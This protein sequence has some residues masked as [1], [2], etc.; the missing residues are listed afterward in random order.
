MEEH[1]NLL[2]CPFC[3]GRA[4][5]AGFVHSDGVIFCTECYATISDSD[6]QTATLSWNTRFSPNK[7]NK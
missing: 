4:E 6:K 5:V 2:N 7:G 1:N 3:G